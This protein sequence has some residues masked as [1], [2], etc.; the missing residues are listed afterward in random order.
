MGQI[1]VYNLGKLGV[2]VDKSPVHLE[3]GELTKAQNVIRNQLGHE[4]GIEKRPGLTKF[5]AVAA[6][7]SVL[8]GIGVPLSLL[9]NT[10]GGTT[11]AGGPSRTIYVGR[12]VT[13]SGIG[14]SRGWWKSTDRFATAASAILSSSP[15]NP[16]SEQIELLATG[17]LL[18]T[19]IG[20]PA[21]SCVLRNKL[22]YASDD[23]TTGAGAPIR[24]FDG[25]VDA[26]FA[27]VTP[28]ATTAIANSFGVM[29]MLAVNDD[30]IYVTVFSDATGTAETGIVLKL[31]IATGVL[32][33]L[34]TITLSA[35][36]VPYALGWH[37][38][39]LWMGT[40]AADSSGPGQIFWIRPGIDTSWTLDR[41]MSLG[42]GCTSLTSFQGQLFAGSLATGGGN[43]V[44]EARSSVGAWT[45][46]L[47]IAAAESKAFLGAIVFQ[48]NLY[49]ASYQ[50]TTATTFIKKFNGSVWSN[51]F[52]GV[53]A[54]NR[55]FPSAFTDGTLVY[56]VGGG[57]A[58]DAGM[59]TSPDG[60]TWT[61]RA[62]SLT[63]GMMGL[64][65][66]GVLAL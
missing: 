40:V 41:T 23:Y 9:T 37:A 13:A 33:P 59:E 11:L 51:A 1:N 44:V 17:G 2:N 30:T 36:H 55:A 25:V 7:G 45:A 46:S 29:S 5:N 58:T 6:G 18:G 8:G 10:V 21:A 64:T 39:R 63:A 32:A 31:N 28:G 38:G 4:G 61:D 3:D 47:T 54:T 22:Y 42:I 35:R 20:S 27:R 48:S 26:E 12:Q 66:Y 53:G 34:G 65:A 60:T 24:V 19:L 49:I 50:F 43:M 15:A 16:R 56:F 14:A 62:S 52:T 57:N